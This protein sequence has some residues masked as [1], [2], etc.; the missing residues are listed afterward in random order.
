VAKSI[1]ESI[2]KS[3]R[4]V[5]EAIVAG[6]DAFCRERLNDEYAQLCRKVAA[7]LCRKRPS[8]L[9]S[10]N[11]TSWICGI[12]YAVGSVNF[13]FDKSQTPYL[14][15][16]DLAA[17]FGVSKSTA[18]SRSRA[19]QDMLK[20]VPFDWHWSLPSRIEDNSLTWM[21]MVNGFI[22]D[23][24]DMPREVQEEAFRK[25]LIPHLPGEDG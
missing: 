1:S 3:M 17:A 10:G 12:V 5:Y 24:R 19:I 25:G 16:A 6:T 9:T 23:V 21:V 13:L 4:P 7:A 8:P 14:S 18:S 15:A 20:M 22:V 11:L 2:P